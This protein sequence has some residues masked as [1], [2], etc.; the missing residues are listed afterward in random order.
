MN[1]TTNLPSAEDIERAEFFLGHARSELEGMEWAFK[2]IREAFGAPTKSTLAARGAGV[3]TSHALA[4]GD[5]LT[6]ELPPVTEADVGRAFLFL[7][8]YV[9]LATDVERRARRLLDQLA[10]LAAEARD[11]VEAATEGAAYSSYAKRL[12]AAL[13]REAVE[14]EKSAARQEVA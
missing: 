1:P 11:E 9:E 3:P 14:L 12:A 10:S 2:A 4:V 7:T 5:A 6:A 8:E 13:R